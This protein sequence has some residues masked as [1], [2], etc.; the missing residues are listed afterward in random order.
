MEAALASVLTGALKAVI[1]K[2]ATLLGDEYKH[3]KGVRKEIKSLN[4][5]LSSMDAFLMKMSA[6]E[7]PDMQD[8]VWMNE[9]RELS[10][11]I[12]DFIDDFLKY[13][14]AEDTKLDSFMEKIKFFLGKMKTRRQI[15]KEIEDLKKQIIEVGERNARYKIH[16]TFS[17]TLSTSVDPRALVIF[18]HASKLV[19]MD[20][21][22]N[23]IIK[24]FKEEDGHVPTKSLLK[25]VSIVGS[26]GMGKTNSCKP[27][28]SRAKRKI[29]LSGF[30]ISV[31]KSRHDDY[32]KNYS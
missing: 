23:E 19:G 2:L 11:D 22:K 27:S 10:Y 4:N 8:K 17:K 12:D 7:D 15:G 14:N 29:Q 28:V 1:G 26:G 31:T 20:A 30:H 6:E 5:E 9:V 32:P 24:L 13:I 18:E 21:P 25:I 3:V 16:E